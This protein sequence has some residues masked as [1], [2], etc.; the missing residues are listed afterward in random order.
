MTA[1]FRINGWL[2][3]GIVEDQCG[4]DLFVDKTGT[5]TQIPLFKIFFSVIPHKN[6]NGIFQQIFLFQCLK[7]FIKTHI[8]VSGTV[9]GSLENLFRIGSGDSGGVEIF[10]V[11]PGVCCFRREV[12]GVMGGLKKHKGEKGIP[13]IRSFFNGADQAFHIPLIPFIGTAPG[14]AVQIFFRN[15]QEYRLIKFRIREF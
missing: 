8:Q 10:Q 3:P 1:H 11:V 12:I 9:Q 15:L 14:I 6:D 5:V 13:G 7:H 4:F 2:D